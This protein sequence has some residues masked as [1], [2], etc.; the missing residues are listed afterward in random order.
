MS[1]ELLT[2]RIYWIFLTAAFAFGCCVGS[3]L[4]VVIYRLPLG[5]S[6]HDPKRSFCP[7]CKYPIPFYHNIPVLSWLLL[8][9]RCAN[10]KSPISIRYPIVE[11]LT[12][13]LFAAAM[14]RFGYDWKVLA[15][16]AFLALCVAG[17]YID[18]DH[19]ILPHE[20]TWGGAAAGLM[21]GT[22][23]PSYYLD[24]PWWMNLLYGLGSAALGYA[25]IWVVIQLGKLAF[26]KLKLSF[27]KP[28]PWS[29]SQPE[30]SLEPILDVAGQKEGWS[31]IFSRRS[32]RLIIRA[33]SATLGETVYGACVL[34]M[35]EDT[36]I[37]TPEGA[38][39]VTLP[40]ESIPSMSG[41]CLGLEQPREA[42]GLGDANWMACVGAFMG[43]KAVLFAIFGGSI[44]GALVSLLMIVLG[45]REWAGRIPFGPYLAAGAVIWLFRGPEFLEWYLNL[46]RG[47]P[48]V[49]G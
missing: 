22:L 40:L 18:I 2:P 11:L 1:P 26:G 49:E 10:C 46:A 6:T 9:A 3:Y 21:A 31:D 25:V 24:G 35:S 29:V 45:R 4:N 5:L 20:I 36:V 38:E 27:E 12:G 43:W 33:A 42:M 7:L 48:V 41:T 47:G 32:D 8:R 13:L 14:I 17:S 44:I 34:K 19:Q 30:G 23:I 15:A 28:E 16:F 37:V 39:P